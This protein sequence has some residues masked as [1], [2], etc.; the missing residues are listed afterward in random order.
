[1]QNIYRYQN[2]KS[3]RTLVFPS[4]QNVHDAHQRMHGT[5]PTRLV[6]PGLHVFYTEDT[7][8][9]SDI[10]LAHSFFFS[11]FSFSSSTYS[12]VSTPCPLP[13]SIPVSPSKYYSSGSKRTLP[14]H[15]ETKGRPRGG[16]GGRKGPGRRTASA[17]GGLSRRDW[18]NKLFS[19]G[20]SLQGSKTQS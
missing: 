5:V 18:E 15:V 4:P 12:T 7:Y 17:S 1:M 14:G 11:L 2:S 6:Y 8:T 19:W 20:C 13:E 16:K 10:S 9:H 3:I